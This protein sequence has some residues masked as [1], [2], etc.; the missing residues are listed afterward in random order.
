MS[1]SQT[2]AATETTTSQWPQAPETTRIEVLQAAIASCD[3]LTTAAEQALATGSVAAVRLA[4]TPAEEVFEEAQQCIVRL[5]A[6]HVTVDAEAASLSS[7]G[8]RLDALWL[9]LVCQRNVTRGSYRNSE[10]EG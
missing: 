10:V 1:D 9:R 4:F 7:L 8:L 5:A 3:C 6:D 2:R